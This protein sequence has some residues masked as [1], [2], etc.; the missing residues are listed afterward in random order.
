MKNN[1]FK[2][3][4]ALVVIGLI[5][6][7]IYYFYNGKDNEEQNTENTE[8]EVSKTI[9]TDVRIAIVNFDSLNPLLSNNQDIQSISRIIY[10]PLLSLEKDYSLNLCLA[11][12]WTKVNN[13]TYLVTL[14][15]GIK[16][17]NG[18]DF[19]AQDVK[20]TVDQLKSG[21]F[22]SIYTANVDHITSLDVVDNYTLRIGLDEEVPFFEYNL[23]FPIMCNDYYAEEDFVSSSKNNNP[24]GT[25]KYKL[26]SV[27]DS[28]ITL[29]QNKKWWNIDNE[30]LKIEEV[31]LKKYNSMGEAYNAFKLGNIDILTTR[32]LNVEEYIGSV[33][34]KTEG[35]RGRNYDYIA[36]NCNNE[37]LED[38]AVRNAIDYA[39]DKYNITT[40]VYGNKYYTSDFPLDYGSFLYNVE[41]GDEGYNPEKSRE[42]LK[43]SGWEFGNEY[44][45]KKINNKVYNTKLN[46]V[47]K[48]S[49]NDRVR[50]AENIKR[51]LEEVGIILNIVQVSD[52]QY[53]KYLNNKNYDLIL[54][55]IIRGYSPDLTR[56]FG[57]GNLANFDN[58]EAMNI[59][60]DLKNITDKKIIKERYNRLIQIYEDEQPYIG[61][62]YNR[63]SI[64]CTLNLMGSIDSNIYNIFYNINDW[65]REY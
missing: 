11:K 2:Y 41:K 59:L 52:S 50:V 30:K 39:I 28:V 5:S 45:S 47:V 7:S 27:E 10:E 40:E 33:G 54:T 8:Q 35:Y 37:V 12:E 63:N 24:V 3:I 6:Y 18:F 53:E 9:L 31:I 1:I 25:G 60:N 46:L 57:D 17:H 36:L 49:N 58:E 21:N 44:W 42:L 62:Y 55:G 64:I 23:T 26:S 16:W 38:K 4:F 19:T 32:N 13:T 56:Y 20:F 22:S 61:L 15:Q 43:I 48:A 29:K 65:Y 34:Y 14:K 51:Q